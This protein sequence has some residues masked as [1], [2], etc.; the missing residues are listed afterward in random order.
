[1]IYPEVSL[2]DW[3]K[4]YPVLEIRRQKCRSCSSVQ[5]TNIPFIEKDWIGLKSLD[6]QCG[7]Y[8]AISVSIANPNSE[9]RAKFENWLTSF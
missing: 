7:K 1:M 4:K 2:K 9:F 6:C 3:L 5:L 8:K